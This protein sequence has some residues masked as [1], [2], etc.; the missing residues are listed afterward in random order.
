MRAS[1]YTTLEVYGNPIRPK[2]IPEWHVS[3]KRSQGDGVNASWGS[4]GYSPFKGQ[5]LNSD[6]QY[7]RGTD[8]VHFRVGGITERIGYSKEIQF[9]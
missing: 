3:M 1:T 7:D 9:R 4:P 6:V 5:I 8:I 2:D